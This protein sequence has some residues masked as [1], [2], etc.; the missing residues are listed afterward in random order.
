MKDFFVEPCY[1]RSTH[2]YGFRCGE[3]AEI[4]GVK[5]SNK[6]P[7]FLVVFDD[8]VTDLWVIAETEGYQFAAKQFIQEAK[9]AA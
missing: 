1:I 4:A 8:G 6:R 5:L 3:W 2:P 7:C 9:T